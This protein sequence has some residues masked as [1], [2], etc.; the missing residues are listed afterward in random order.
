M[1]RYSMKSCSTQVQTKPLPK[2]REFRRKSDWNS[3]AI[4]IVISIAIHLRSQ[5]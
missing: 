5:L 1:T 4:S 2:R 3:I